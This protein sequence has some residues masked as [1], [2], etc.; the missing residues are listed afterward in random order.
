MRFSII[1]VNYK[2]PRLVV[3]CLQSLYTGTMQDTEIIVVDNNSGDN[4]EQ[5]IRQAC[6]E[7][8]WIQMGYNSGFARAN[9]AGIRQAA[10]ATILLL[11]SDTININNA[12][13]RCFERLENDSCIAAGVQLLNEDGSPQISGNFFM[14]GGLNYLMT[15]P[16]T[17]E[18]IRRIAVNAGVKKTNV[19]EA[20]ATVEVDWIN[21]AFLMVK[22]AAIEKAG[23]MD[24][25]FFLYAEES[26]WCS[27]LKK[28][29]TLC[30]YGDL[31]IYHL[32]GG[33]S[34][35]A[36]RSATKG[37]RTYAAKKGLQIMVSNFLGFRKQYGIGWY[38]FHQMAHLGN[39][40]LYFLI[41]LFRSILFP[42]NIQEEWSS[43]GGYSGNVF[44]A[45]ALSPK[46]IA[47]RPYFYRML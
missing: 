32:E 17:G 43:F 2:T 9:N 10:G 21:G 38:L 1:I 7:V 16:Y 33:S 46:I 30:I 13:Y 8:Q 44:K 27:R 34:K 22:K 20:T 36:F 15:L 12:V 19:P 41:L 5:C 24:E 29:G 23:L 37:Y 11:N 40:P 39:I 6:P 26:E 42:G 18:L 25:D 47:N 4:S 3:Q 31:N 35:T 14:K 45:L 28:I